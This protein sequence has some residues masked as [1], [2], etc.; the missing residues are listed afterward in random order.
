MSNEYTTG[1][2]FTSNLP[3]WQRDYYSLLL[4]ETLRSQSIM[5]PFTEYVEDFSAANSGRII[6]TEVYDTAPDWGALTETDIWLRGAHLDSRTVSIDLEIH[7]DILKFSDYNQIQNYVN[8]GNM[9]GLVSDK[10]G[11]NMK[12]YLDILARNAF[13]EHPDK[14]YG[15][16]ATTRAELVAADI[17]DADICENIRTDMEENDIPGIANPGDGDSQTIVCVT[18]PRVLHDIR[19]AA[20]SSWLEVQEYEQTGRKFTSE[21]GMWGGVRFIKSNRLKLWNAGDSTAG[22]QTALQGATVAGQ[23]AAATVDTVYTPGQTGSTRT[24]TVDDTTGISVG[25]YVTIHDQ[26]DT[27]VLETDGS[28]ETRRVVAVTGTTGGTLAFDKPLLKPHADND[29]VTSALD[30]HSAIF[31]GGPS[32]VFGVG[33]APFVITPPKYDDLMMVNRYG[34]RGFL[35]FQMFRPEF[36]RVVEAAGSA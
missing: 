27:E 16:D 1:A 34:W 31:I 28:Q 29:L 7:G 2:L 22:V 18:T 5:V 10:I 35:K 20:G 26:G 25:D 11:W 15:G 13:L 6:F 32:V 12:E 19:T 33:Q 17:F 9:A 4:M 36:F 24:V 23:G 30:V 14:D 8:R 3:S 21:V